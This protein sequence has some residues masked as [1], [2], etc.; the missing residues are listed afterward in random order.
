MNFVLYLGHLRD[1]GSQWCNRLPTKIRRYR[2]M[3][4]IVL[5][6]TVVALMMTSLAFGAGPAAA[7]IITDKA[8]CKEYKPLYK[9]YGFTQ[10]ACIKRVNSL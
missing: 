7:Q 2:F 3:R 4:R 5:L 8:V 9:P 6:A 10:G 1:G